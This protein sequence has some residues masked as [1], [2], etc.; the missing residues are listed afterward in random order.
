MTTTIFDPPRDFCLE[1]L[2]YS[3]FREFTL[4]AQVNR[5]FRACASTIFRSRVV[6]RISLCLA[7]RL[8]PAAQRF[9]ATRR[10]MDLLRGE[11]GCITGSLVQSLLC[12]SAAAE[13]P[14]Y[15]WPRPNMNIILTQSRVRSCVRLLIE[16]Y[17]FELTKVERSVVRD[18]YTGVSLPRCTFSDITITVSCTRSPSVLRVLLASR[19]TSQ[20]NALTA[21][22]LISFQPHMTMRGTGL[23]AWPAVARRIAQDALSVRVSSLLLRHFEADDTRP[24]WNALNAG[25]GG[26][27]GSA[28]VWITQVNPAWLPSDLN[29]VVSKGRS[30]V[31]RL[32]LQDRGWTESSIDSLISRVS[33][34]DGE[35]SIPAHGG[36]DVYLEQTWLYEKG[37]RPTITLTE[38]CDSS[39]LR[40]L[41]AA[42]HSLAT[43]LLTS[44]TIIA[45]HARDCVRRVATWRESRDMWWTEEQRLAGQKVFA[46]EGQDPAPTQLRNPCGKTC[47]GRVRRLRGG[48]GVG[49]LA[50]QP[51]GAR[52]SRNDTRDDV[53]GACDHLDHGDADA[54]EVDIV[55]RDAY[56]GFPHLDYAFGWTWR[57][58]ENHWC[59]TFDFPRDL[60]PTLPFNLL[61][62]PNPKENTILRR[63]HAVQHC[64]PP[65][66][67][68]YRGLLFPT[69]C[70]HPLEVPVP[71]D[72][73]VTEYHSMDDL[74]AWT[75]ITPR[76]E[77]LEP[78]PI[79]LPPCDVRGSP[80]L[81]SPL[82]WRAQYHEN[83][84]LL[85]FMSSVHE[86]G[87][88]NKLIAAER[89][90]AV[91][92]DVLL[93][94]EEHGAIVDVSLSDV[95][96]LTDMFTSMWA[97]KTSAGE[98]YA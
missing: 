98:E 82:S 34:A 63:A 69:S 38:T 55:A 44:T 83:C 48:S 28:P 18:E 96:R 20:M 94:L 19:T 53:G 17:G 66:P 22:H 43:T 89:P 15:Q 71:L 14:M 8:A 64:D 49:I 93:L 27:V 85:V 47:P 37:G 97:S 32:F 36:E 80:T 77:G 46:M 57:T 12:F 40:H 78:Y 4:L 72:H 87:P 52:I 11:G 10:L 21:T 76:I 81:F 5:L 7:I 23:L 62:S 95:G 33:L 67:H 2:R 61:L 30:S 25:R 70:A 35:T 68:T 16:V 41:T 73:G 39:V 3:R 86:I 74:R 26:I 90:R 50:W 65:F 54:D 24:F 51:L 60:L 42:E 92:G 31:A 88:L 59:S 45:L 13:W 75:W 6:A 84:F 9:E 1:L 58:C 91:H 29:T 56:D 79:F